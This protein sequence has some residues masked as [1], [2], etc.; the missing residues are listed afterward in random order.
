MQQLDRNINVITPRGPALA[1]GIGTGDQETTIWF[2][3]IKATG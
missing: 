2:V 1:I 3:F